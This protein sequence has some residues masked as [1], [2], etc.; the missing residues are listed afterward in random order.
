M[1]LLS[2][3][4]PRSQRGWGC[5]R[6]KLLS[7]KVEVPHDLGSRACKRGAAAGVAGAAGSVD[8]TGAAV[9]NR[10]LLLG[11]YQRREVA[12]MR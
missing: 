2:S 5:F 7:P 8:A 9:W 4:K 12:R 10:R 3:S 11:F 1:N 6:P